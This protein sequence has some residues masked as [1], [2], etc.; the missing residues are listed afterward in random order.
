MAYHY[1]L[2]QSLESVCKEIS[3]EVKSKDERSLKLTAWEDM[4]PNKFSNAV[5][6]FID[7]Y[8]VQNQ[9]MILV[10]RSFQRLVTN[11]L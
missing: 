11:F 2:F 1:E 9:N 5:D 3:F 8:Q 6:K 4:D 7:F 10:G